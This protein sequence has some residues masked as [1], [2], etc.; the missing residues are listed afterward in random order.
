MPST[1]DIIA[2]F[3]NGFLMQCITA[4]RMVLRVSEPYSTAAEIQNGYRNGSIKKNIIQN[5]FINEL[6]NTA[7]KA[8]QRT[9]VPRAAELS[10]LQ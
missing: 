3:L 1:T 2:S 5:I 4:L 9:L 7:N 6:A 8:L 10:V